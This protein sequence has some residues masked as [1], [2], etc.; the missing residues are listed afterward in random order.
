MRLAILGVIGKESGFMPQSEKGYGNT[1]NSRIVQ[2]FGDRVS[3]ENLPDG[4]T[5]DQLK[6][7]D[8]AFFNHV[9]GGKYGNDDPGDGYRYRGRGFN[10]ITFKGTYEKYGLGGDPDSL[11]D[12]AVAARVAVEFLSKRL[13]RLKGRDHEYDDINDAVDDAAQANAGLGKR[14]SA[15]SRAV[16]TTK[17]AIRK[18]FSNEPEVSEIS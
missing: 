6:A 18:H 17:A 16:N 14:G 1:S 10:Q 3:S 11:N 5:L 15:L 12:P 8:E 4:K 7:D 9:Y 2:I 13:D